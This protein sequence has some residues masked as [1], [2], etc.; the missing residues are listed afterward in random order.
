MSKVLDFAVCFA[1]CATNN[2]FDPLELA[3]LI[4][5]SDRAFKAGEAY[6]NLPGDR[7][8]KANTRTK[9]KV[10]LHAEKMGLVTEWPGLWPMF[11]NAKTGYGIHIPT[12]N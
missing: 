7:Y 8:E 5:L 9:N 6:C 1:R 12:P 4:R 2:G 3:E 10:K 11:K